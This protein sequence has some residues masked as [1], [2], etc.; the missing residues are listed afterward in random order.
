MLEVTEY[1]QN[2]RF[3]LV[4]KHG[5]SFSDIDEKETRFLVLKNY[6]ECSFRQQLESV[7]CMFYFP[8]AE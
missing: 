7:R 4:W 2:I 8:Q 5:I 6:R 1:L 3:M